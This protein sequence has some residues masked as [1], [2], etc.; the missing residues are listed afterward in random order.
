MQTQTSLMDCLLT[1]IALLS[2]VEVQ[3]C[4]FRDGETSLAC[5][6]Y[7]AENVPIM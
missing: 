7:F 1:A 5:L 3:E 2:E 4:Y 6:H